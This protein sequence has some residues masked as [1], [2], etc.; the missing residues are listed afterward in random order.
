MS[1]PNTD[2]TYLQCQTQ[3]GLLLN[4]ARQVNAAAGDLTSVE[5]PAPAIYATFP[6]ICLPPATNR[7]QLMYGIYFSQGREAPIWLQD[8]QPPLS[9]SNNN[10]EDGRELADK[11]MT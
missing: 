4:L 9:S 5:E 6:K 2:I 11:Q 7:A 8:E 10:T 1:P 3:E